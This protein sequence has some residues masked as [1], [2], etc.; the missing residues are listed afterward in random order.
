MSRREDTEE[1]K[2][3]QRREGGREGRGIRER[4]P[5]AEIGKGLKVGDVE[6]EGKG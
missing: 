4:G 1:G 5:R 2:G 6:E 3:G